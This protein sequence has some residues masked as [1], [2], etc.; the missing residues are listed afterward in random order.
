MNNESTQNTLVKPRHVLLLQRG[1]EGYGVSSTVTEFALA[2][3]RFQ[4]TVTLVC[5]TDGRLCEK[6]REAGFDVDVLDVKLPSRVLDGSLPKR[7]LLTMESAASQRRIARVVIERYQGASIDVVQ[8]MNLLLLESCGR[9]AKAL[10]ASGVWRM[11]SGVQTA[12]NRRIKQLMMCRVCNKHGLINMANS[13][14]TK[15][16]IARDSPLSVSVH[17][18]C[19]PVRF[20]PDTVTSVSREAF[21]IGASD[22]VFGVFAHITPN[23]QKGQHLAV[24]ALIEHIKRRPAA[25]SPIHLLVLGDPIDSDYVARFRAAADTCDSLVLHLPGSVPDVER[26]YKLIDVSMS[27][28][29]TPEP[30]GL[31]VIES[32]MMG[33]PVLAHALGGPAE[34]IID[35]QTGWLV[36][37]TDVENWT[38]A[39]DRV[40]AVRNKWP[41]FSAAARAHALEHFTV[42]VEV[43][44]WAATLDALGV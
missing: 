36:S 12:K 16:S 18:G 35:N 1:D 42:D 15:L 39:I 6:L 40:I 2:L 26:Y 34:T 17:H 4:Q 10:K 20:N 33:V 31:S 28:R 9:I 32:M 8:S 13:E 11:P 44:N 3:K 7:A 37:D 19:N 5:V 25:A 24:Q 41:E 29:I 38:A 22:I 27:T 21:G 30:F 43:I 14:F 23:G